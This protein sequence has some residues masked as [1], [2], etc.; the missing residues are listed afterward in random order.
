MSTGIVPQVTVQATDFVPEVF[1]RWTTLTPWYM[2]DF[3]TYTKKCHRVRCECGTVKQVAR[4]CLLHSRSKSCG[5]LIREVARAMGAGKM[6]HGHAKRRS[7]E[8]RAWEGMRSRCS[9]AT[10]PAYKDYGGRGIRVFADWGCPGGFERWLAHIGPRP[11]GKYSIDRFPNPNGNYEPGNVRW[12]T[13]EEQ[14][15]NTRAN[16]VLAYMGQNKTKAQWAK[17]LDIAYHTL[18]SRLHL[19]WSIEK[20]LSTPVRKKQKPHQR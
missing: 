2:V 6:T 7:P 1:N 13:D 17:E 18:C 3:G 9:K 11:S 4:S 20:A 15:N 12:A 5:C 14:Q 19:G 10:H 8:Y 16:V